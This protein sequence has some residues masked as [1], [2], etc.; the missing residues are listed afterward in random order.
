MADN[1]DMTIS[2]CSALC[3]PVSKQQEKVFMEFWTAGVMMYEQ[4]MRDFTFRDSTSRQVQL[5]FISSV[6]FTSDQPA[7]SPIFFQLQ[8][9]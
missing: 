2:F 4:L 3:F 5:I 7:P 8:R 1:A 6:N 9:Y